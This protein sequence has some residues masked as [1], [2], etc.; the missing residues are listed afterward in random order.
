MESLLLR[1]PADIGG[2]YEDKIGV[3]PLGDTD[4]RPATQASEIVLRLR[5]SR[6]SQPRN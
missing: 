3:S 1:E 5:L 2:Y 4:D 6:L